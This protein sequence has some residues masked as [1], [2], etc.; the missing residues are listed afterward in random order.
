MSTQAKIVAAA[1]IVLC[2]L[3]IGAA[4]ML[5]YRALA[6]ERYLIVQDRWTGHV[7]VQP[8][9]QSIGENWD[10]IPQKRTP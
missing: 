6:H 2:A 10:W 9:A 7:Y 8:L 3:S 4:H 1:L 5:R